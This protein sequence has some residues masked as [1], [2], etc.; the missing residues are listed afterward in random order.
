MCCE[1]PPAILNDAIP[2]IGW[3]QVIDTFMM[4]SWNRNI[5]RVTGHLCG[6]Q[7]PVTRSFDVF[8]DLRLNKR[9]SKHLRGWWLEKPSRPLWHHCNVIETWQTIWSIFRLSIYTRKITGW[10][11]WF[12][13]RSVAFMSDRPV[14]VSHLV[15]N[16][17][18]DALI[19]V[20]S[21]LC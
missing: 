7:R 15:Q 21:F 1:I 11:C 10:H 6:E 16:I 12:N 3:Y 8:F 20:L 5:F 13:T 9:M 2:S 19:E 4:T 14:H 17:T 18:T